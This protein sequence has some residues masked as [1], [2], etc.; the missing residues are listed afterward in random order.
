MLG[1]LRRNGVAHALRASAPR[2]L[3][4]RVTSQRLNWHPPSLSAVSHVPRSLFHASQFSY[5]AVAQAQ[6]QTTEPETDQSERLTEFKQLADQRL[7]DPVII[8]TITKT[9]KIETMTEVQS[10]TIRQSLNGND[11]LAQAKTGTGKT[12]AFL[13]PVLQNIMNDPTVDRRFQRGFRSPDIRAIIVSPTRELAEQI[14]TEARKL[15]SETGI[16]VQTA[17]GGTRKADGLRR[18]QKQ[19]C[20]LL[21]GTPGRLEDIL[22]DPS[23]RV[24]APKLSTFVL[25]EADRLLDDGFAPDLM[26]IQSLLPNPNEVDRQTLMFSATIPREVMAMVNRTMK[27]GYEMIKTVKDNEVPTHLTVPQKLVLLDGWQ[28]AFPSILELAKNYLAQKERDHSLRP[29]KAIVYL[30]ATLQVS[31]AYRLFTRLLEDPE[32]HRSGS[33]LKKVYIHELHSRMS[34]AR[35]GN[36]SDF[37]RSCRSG[38]LFSSDVSAR[39]LDFPD[40]THVI[41]IGVPA[42]RDTYIHRIGRTGRANKQGE[43]WLMIHPGEHAWIQRKLGDLPLEKDDTLAGALVDMS[44]ESSEDVPLVARESRTQVQTA[45]RQLSEEDREQ[46]WKSQFGSLTSVFSRQK[47][48]ILAMNDMATFGYCLPQP[49]AVSSRMVSNMNLSGVSGLNVRDYGDNRNSRSFRGGSQSRGRGYNRDSNNDRRHNRERNNDRG[50]N[51]DSNNDR[52][53]NSGRDRSSGRDRR[54]RY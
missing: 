10:M 7:V 34:Q 51:R 15:A 49:P 52:R 54:D 12:L 14:A 46:A 33:P 40:V 37:F 53:Y 43:A 47:D 4:A 9:M 39:G 21:V 41:Q 28:N 44:Q 26:K 27:P 22:S 36:T 11:V 16:V 17:V 25:D 20:H 31:L 1:A 24:E 48:M 23:T 8:R 2:F 19:G 38:I 35:R 30:N 13:V 45:M 42:S 6:E 5:S 3:S 32:D 50:Y 29:F 18:I